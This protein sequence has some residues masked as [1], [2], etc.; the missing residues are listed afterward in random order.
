MRTNIEI[1]EHLMA[2]AMKAGPFKTRKDAVEAG[3]KLL[4]RQAAY[5]EIL[6]WEGR[7]KWK[8]DENVEWA[9]PAP[10]ARGEAHEP[11][12]RRRRA[13]R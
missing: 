10:S 5:R 8:G 4:A 13:G 3:L 6:K 9:A 11:A 1:D 2:E 12:T 7:L